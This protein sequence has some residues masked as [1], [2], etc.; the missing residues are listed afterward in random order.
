MKKVLYILALI[1]S[2]LSM[3]AQNLSLTDTT[4]FDFWVG[5]WEASWTNA[6][7]TTGTGKNSIKKILDDKVIQENFS[8]SQ[9]FKGTSI[10]VFNK[11][12]KTWHQA[13]A[14]N[15]GG[16]YNFLGEVEGS[17]RIFR[18]PT[19]E[20]GGKLM[21]LRMVFYDITPKSMMWDWEK[22]SDGGKTW[23]LQWRIAYKKK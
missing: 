7:G 8:D 1:F 2:S 12:R 19:R 11:Q 20:I 15:Q 3:T 23:E 18:T 14:D 9:G 5:E 4:L 22:S 13:W 17:K 10:T 6:D 21:T 16:Y